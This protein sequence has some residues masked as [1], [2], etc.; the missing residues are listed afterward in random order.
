MSE[1]NKQKSGVHFS[2]GK[3]FLWLFVYACLFCILVGLNMR[4]DQL[5][6]ATL[7]VTAFIFIDL[8][9]DTPGYH[10]IPKLSRYSKTLSFFLLSFA[11]SM[12]IC[13]GLDQYFPSPTPPPKLLA[14]TSFAELLAEVKNEYQAGSDAFG[15]SIEKIILTRMLFSLFSSIAFC[16]ALLSLKQF[17]SAKWLLAFS[18]PGLLLA[19]YVII[20]GVIG[21]VEG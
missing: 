3:L 14:V 16:L 7:L 8:R 1:I 19:I 17:S 10:K 2:L 18:L 9:A 20:S 6:A 13:D 4:L 11:L 21:T 15:K 5:L 12:A